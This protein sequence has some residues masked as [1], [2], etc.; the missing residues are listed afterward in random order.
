[1]A[2]HRTQFSDRVPGTEIRFS[3]VVEGEVGAHRSHVGLGLAA[4]IDAAWRHDVTPVLG[5]ASYEALLTDLRQRGLSS[6]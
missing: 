3:K 1:M 4:R 2:A 5:H 6:R